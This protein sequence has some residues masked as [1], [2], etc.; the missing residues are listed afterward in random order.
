MRVQTVRLPDDLA[1]RLDEAAS[2]TRRTKT[3]FI[4]EALERLLE[5]REDLRLAMDR[6]RDPKAEWI[7]H[8]EVRRALDLD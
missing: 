4:L 5:D 7:D 1:R 6:I 3:S 8:D 2:A